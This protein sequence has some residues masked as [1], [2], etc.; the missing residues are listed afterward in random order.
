MK[1][2][3]EGF[4]VGSGCGWNWGPECWYLGIWEKTCCVCCAGALRSVLSDIC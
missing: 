2:K 1:R 4:F 3:R